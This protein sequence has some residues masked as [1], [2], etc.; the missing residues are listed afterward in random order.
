MAYYKGKGKKTFW[1]HGGS[2]FKGPTKATIMQSK[3]AGWFDIVTPYNADFVENLKS[4]ISPAYR[5]WDPAN[6]LW[7][8]R[9]S[10]LE[11]VV[12]LLMVYY[13]TVESSVGGS[14]TNSTNAPSVGGNMFDELFSTLKGL[15]NGN[16]DKVYLALSKGVHPDTGGTNDLMRQL[17]EAYQKNKP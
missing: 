4:L 12:N 8:I 3:D 15:P 2:T 7:K 5:R 10:A 14:T 13:D 16:M 1:G 6:K 9:E 11:D 17:N